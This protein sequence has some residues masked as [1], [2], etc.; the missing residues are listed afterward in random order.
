MDLLVESHVAGARHDDHAR[1]APGVGA[2][3]QGI[4]QRLLRAPAAGLAA[5]RQRGGGG[6]V[7]EASQHG[8]GEPSEDLRADRGRRAVLR[9]LLR[10]SPAGGAA[11][12]PWKAVRARP[13]VAQVLAQ[14]QAGL[15]GPPPARAGQGP[16]GVHRGP[17]LGGRAHRRLPQLGAGPLRG[18]DRA[19][20]R[21]DRRACAARSAR[22]SRC[23]WSTRT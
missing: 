23:R 6:G 18:G 22:P 5:E 16:G 10:Q 4:R 1:E 7:P 11:G 2:G 17:R 13:E 9:A 14:L 20:D 21:G 12:G 3:E 19:A 8:L 15:P